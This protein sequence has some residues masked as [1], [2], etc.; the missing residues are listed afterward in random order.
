MCASTWTHLHPLHYPPN[1]TCCVCT[2]GEGGSVSGL[3]RATPLCSTTPRT[4]IHCGSD[5]V[6]PGRTVELPWHCLVHPWPGALRVES[7]YRPLDIVISNLDILAAAVD[8]IIEAPGPRRWYVRILVHGGVAGP[9]GFWPPQ[10][11]LSRAYTKYNRTS[12]SFFKNGV[13][14]W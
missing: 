10:P 5:D 9:A 3:T 13:A 11:F 7:L 12:S 8:D 6:C 4:L 2:V 1:G 14:W